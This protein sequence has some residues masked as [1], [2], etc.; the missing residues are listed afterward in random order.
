MNIKNVCKNKTNFS[1]ETKLE[2]EGKKY[3]VFLNKIIKTTL[4]KLNE[5]LNE[6]QLQEISNKTLSKNNL[7]F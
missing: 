3:F 2:N 7:N 1:I 4:S 5:Y 6:A